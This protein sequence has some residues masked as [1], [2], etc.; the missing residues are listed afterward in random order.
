MTKIYRVG[1]IVTGRVTGIQPYGIFVELDENTQ[2][3]VHISEIT[4]GYVRDIHQYVNIGETIRVKVIGIDDNR[5]RVSLSIRALKRPPRKQRRF[6]ETKHALE[7]R[8]HERD[9]I[10]FQSLKE[11][12]HEWIEKT[13]IN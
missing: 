8:V 9:E 5:H 2:G 4:Y 12:L 3:L 7:K 6:F 10:G 1:D 11:K 13:D